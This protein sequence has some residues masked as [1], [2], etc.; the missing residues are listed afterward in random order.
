MPLFMERIMKNEKRVCQ[1]CK[2]EFDNKKHSKTAEHIIPKGLIDLFPDQ[3]ITFSGNR[4]FIDNNGLT[5]SDVCQ[6]CNGT[7]LSP[8]DR[9]GKNLIQNSFLNKIPVDMMDEIL[10]AVEFDYYKLSR[11]LLKITY[12]HQRSKKHN[13]G[14]FQK[15]L[16][17]MIYGLRVENIDFS[18][19]VGVHINTTPLPEEFYTYMPLQINEDPKLYGNSLAVVTLGLNPNINSVKVE[20]A[21]ATYSIRFGTVVF[22]IILWDNNANYIQRLFFNKLMTTEFSFQKIVPSQIL[23]QLKRVSAHSNTTMGY[24]HLIS[25]S[26][27]KQDDMFIKG[28]INGKSLSECQD[29]LY[30]LKGK[31]E[32]EKTRT[33]IEMIDFPDN[34]KIR[35]KYERYFGSE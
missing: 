24:S 22:Y 18:I 31:E 11:W 2:T 32:M 20:G 19:F 4:K 13:I 28:S 9:Y 34:K 10:P 15:A 17:Y 3:Y 33:L 14:W 8:L 26:G 35:K 25:T 7:L 29:V 30:K 1:Y 12:N 16:G 5:I 27:I 23:Y 21:F 6:K